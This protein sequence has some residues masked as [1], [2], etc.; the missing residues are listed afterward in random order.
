MMSGVYQLAWF[1][2][3][4]EYSKWAR[5]KR[6]LDLEGA[7]KND[8][9]SIAQEDPSQMLWVCLDISSLSVFGQLY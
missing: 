1:P 9:K 3:L 7:F 4:L 5:I 6:L 2:E 8:L